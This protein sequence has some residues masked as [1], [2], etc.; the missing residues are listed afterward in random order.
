MNVKK[1]NSRWYTT[2]DGRT[3]GIVTVETP[4]GEVKEYIG[5]GGGVDQEL[6]EDMIC[7]L[8]TRFYG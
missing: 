3:I 8:G 1:L 2:R 6:D 7:D 4:T 5:V